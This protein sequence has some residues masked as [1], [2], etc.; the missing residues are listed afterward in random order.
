VDRR[1]VAK[2]G[3]MMVMLLLL[4]TPRRYTSYAMLQARHAAS[5]SCV[6]YT[7]HAQSPANITT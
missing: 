6:S 7:M 2:E 3:D 4:L 5:K 1:H